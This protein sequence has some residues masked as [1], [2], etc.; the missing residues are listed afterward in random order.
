[1]QTNIQQKVERLNL[2]YHRIITN[3]YADQ[4]EELFKSLVKQLKIWGYK[5]VMGN[6]QI[7]F[8]AF[9]LNETETR[10]YDLLG[11]IQM[12]KRYGEIN[13]FRSFTN[14][15]RNSEISLYREIYISLCKREEIK[16][17]YFRM[18]GIGN[19]IDFIQSGHRIDAYILF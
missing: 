3:K 19:K 4:D 12:A 2:L 15:M 5:F 11:L 13:H 14:S 9:D 16:N 10:H 7:N 17:G 1:M 8:S 6:P 18:D